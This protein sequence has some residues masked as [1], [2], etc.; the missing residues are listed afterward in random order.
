MAKLWSTEDLLGQDER[1]LLV[2]HHRLNYCSLKTLIK[3][4]D[5]GIIP[6]KLISIRKIPPFVA[7][8]F[9]NYHKRPWRNKGKLSSGSIKNPS[10]TRPG[11]MN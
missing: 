1:E 10:E 4:S 3:L 2:C 6:R 7:Y 8:I 11:A 9:E 5:R